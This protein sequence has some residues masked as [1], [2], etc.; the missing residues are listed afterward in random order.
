MPTD[1][2]AAGAVA[3]DTPGLVKPV[4]KRFVSPKYPAAAMRENV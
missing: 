1:G 2:F 4:E 3:P